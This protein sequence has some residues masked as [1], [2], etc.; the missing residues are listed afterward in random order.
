M[1][2]IPAIIGNG[3]TGMSIAK[4]IWSSPASSRLIPDLGAAIEQIYFASRL[5]WMPMWEFA[6][7]QIPMIIAVAILAAMVERAINAL[8]SLAINSRAVGAGQEHTL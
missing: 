3:L 7:A 2:G 5:R 1:K 8:S 4:V 6:L